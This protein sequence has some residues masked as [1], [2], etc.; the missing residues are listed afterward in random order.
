MQ[1]VALRLTHLPAC[2]PTARS[3]QLGHMF[4][5]PPVKG[6]IAEQVIGNILQTHRQTAKLLGLK[7]LV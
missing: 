6:Q 3:P 2:L 1:S 7:P 4:F 5:W